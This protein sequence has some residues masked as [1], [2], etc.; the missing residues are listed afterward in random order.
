MS[1]S[2]EMTITIHSVNHSM[3]HHFGDVTFHTKFSST[4][5]FM[6]LYLCVLTHIHTCMWLL[7]FVW[8]K[9]LIQFTL[10]FI[11]THSYTT[12][13]KKKDQFQRNGKCINAQSVAK[14]HASLWSILNILFDSFEDW[15]SYTITSSKNL[16]LI[17][18]KGMIKTK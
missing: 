18:R 3:D 9:H 15:E 16:K 8:C 1:S 7:R 10:F 2:I 5:H 11:Y 17:K 12:T 13:E 14:D 6:R 4:T